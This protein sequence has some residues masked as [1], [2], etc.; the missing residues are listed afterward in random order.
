[1]RLGQQCRGL[2]IKYDP[3]PSAVSAAN[4]R[5]ATDAMRAIWEAGLRVP[6][7][8]S[9]IGLDDIELAGYQNPSLRTTRQ[10]LEQITRLAVQVVLD[11]LQGEEPPETHIV[12]RPTLLLRQSTGA[13]C[14]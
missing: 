9:L 3:P 5:M 10:P 11:I 2:L 8:I 14:P 13:P 1:V 6:A 7:D 4:D 12:M